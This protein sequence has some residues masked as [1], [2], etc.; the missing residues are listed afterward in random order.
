MIRQTGGF[1][2]GATSTRSSSCSR[3]IASAWGSGCTPSCSPSAAISSTSRAR[4]RS[5]IL[6][7]SAAA[8]LASPLTIGDPPAPSQTAV[9]SKR[10]VRRATWVGRREDDP[11]SAATHLGALSDPGPRTPAGWGHRRRS[12]C[13][14]TSVSHFPTGLPCED[15]R[16]SSLW[17]PYGEEPVPP[18]GAGSPP[19]GGGSGGGPG[20]PRRSPG[21]PARPRTSIPEQMREMLDPAR[22]DA[23]RG[24]RHPVR[25]RAPGDR[26]PAPRARVGAA[27]VARP[28][29]DR[30]DAMAGLVDAVG[31]RLG[32]NAEPLRQARRR[33][34][35]RVRRGQ[36]RDRRAG[37]PPRRVRR[38]LWI[39]IWIAS[40]SSC[41]SA[42][43]VAGD[44][45]QPGEVVLG[46][47]GRRRRRPRA[48][49]LDAGRRAH[50][51]RL[52]RLSSRYGTRPIPVGA[53]TITDVRVS[54]DGRPLSRRRARRTTSCGSS[55]P[56]TSSARSTS[57][58]R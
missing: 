44:T 2:F 22:R 55:T 58:T 16:V 37:E 57:R 30:V 17:T 36:R 5:L 24:D 27:R 33:A 51:L 42:G 47:P 39:A 14:P 31:D 18:A 41:S 11:D 6:A 19:P 21:G 43:I 56:R 9:T 1:A 13:A 7:S 53:Y 20:G 23:G 46:P 54:E 32:P 48:R 15:T 38:R 8:M 34:A 52:H 28:G 10:S 4:M 50:H 26:G 3:A 12:A 29:R 25:G 49:R 45:P 40:S 35:A